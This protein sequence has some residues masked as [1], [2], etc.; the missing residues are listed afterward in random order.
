M[1]VDRHHDITVRQEP[2]A[3]ER[4]EGT[5][6]ILRTM[7]R[8]PMGTVKI[9]GFFIA[10]VAGYYALTGTIADVKANSEAHYKDLS[11]ELARNNERVLAKIEGL[12]QND[13]AQ[14]QRTEAIY[15]RGD[16]RW[17]QVQTKLADNDVKFARVESALNYLVRRAGR[18]EDIA[19]D[20]TPVQ[21]PGK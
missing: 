3:D 11:T 10:A 14:T 5:D 4:G 21:P 15:T 1:M 13:V 19:P 12:V 9:I 20:F 17:G 18:N 8:N 16:L 7:M 2:T 6:A